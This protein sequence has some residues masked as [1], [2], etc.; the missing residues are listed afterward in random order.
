M[1]NVNSDLIANHYAGPRVNSPVGQLHG[2]L[3]VAGGNFEVTGTLI[4]ASGDTIRLARLP[5]NARVWQIWIGGD[6]MDD[7]TNVALDVGL[8][9]PGTDGTA[10]GAVVVTAASDG[11]VLF[12]SAVTMQAVRSMT[13][14]VSED[15]VAA[16]AKI[17]FF[18]HRLFELAEDT[19]GAFAHYEI[20]ATAT[21]TAG[22]VIATSTFAFMIMYTVD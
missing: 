20:V 22:S 4:D 5:A 14:V 7:S 3:R 9:E 17:L 6:D 13:E 8:Y 2:R 19:E 12:A 21:A 1:T 10:P 18:G 11:L 16:D 15:W